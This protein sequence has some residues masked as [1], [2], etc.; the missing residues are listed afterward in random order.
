M[1]RQYNFFYMIQVD[2]QT[3][4]VTKKLELVTE[5]SVAKLQNSLLILFRDG[6]AIDY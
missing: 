5:N 2:E 3:L 6:L 4:I 1:I